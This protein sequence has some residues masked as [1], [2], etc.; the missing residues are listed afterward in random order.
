[1]ANDQPVRHGLYKY[2][3]LDS[4]VPVDYLICRCT[5]GV[6]QYNYKTL[7]VVVSIVE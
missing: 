6:M 1:M 3:G 2:G 5:H 7:M 4:F